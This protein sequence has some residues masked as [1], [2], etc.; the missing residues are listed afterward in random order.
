ME[1][2]DDG[3]QSRF[4]KV[5]TTIMSY[6]VCNRLLSLWWSLHRRLDLCVCMPQCN[7]NLVHCD[8]FVPLAGN[9]KIISYSK[10]ELNRIL[11]PVKA[12][13]TVIYLLFSHFLTVSQF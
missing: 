3:F 2:F 12:M 1:T 9:M 6:P 4:S 10:L 7:G 13:H 11:K 8:Q 5:I